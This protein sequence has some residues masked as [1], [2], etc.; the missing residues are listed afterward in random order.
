[1]TFE[2]RTELDFISNYAFFSS[3]IKNFKLTKIKSK[4]ELNSLNFRFDVIEFPPKLYL[5]NHE[6][7]IHTEKILCP[8]SSPQTLAYFRFYEDIK[9]DI[10]TNQNLEL[11]SKVIV[12]M[13]FLS[14]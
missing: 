11:Y 6:I 1:M 5:K 10:D 4:L 3:S 8:R 9:L 2:E 12:I 14:S 13:G 7:A